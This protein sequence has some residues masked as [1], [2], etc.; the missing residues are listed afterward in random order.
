MKCFELNKELNRYLRAVDRALV[1]PRALRR[2]V[3]ARLRDGAQDYI[4]AH[5][6][7]EWGQVEAHFGAPKAIADEVLSTMEPGVVRRYAKRT[8]V[9]RIVVIG[10]IAGALVWYGSLMLLRAAYAAQET[11]VITIGP[12]MEEDSMPPKPTD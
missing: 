1:C 9:L 8:R 7:V 2:Q 4:D 6:G 12:A 3:V 11:V 5:P 10:L